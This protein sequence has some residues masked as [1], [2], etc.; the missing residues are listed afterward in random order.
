MNQLQYNAI[1]EIVEP[2]QPLV[3]NTRGFMPALEGKALAYALLNC[4]SDPKFPAVEIGSYMGLSSLYLGAVAR[5]TGRKLISIDHHRGSEEN[6]AGWQ[7]HDPTSVDHVAGKIDTLYRFRRTIDLAELDQTI[8]AVVSDSQIFANLLNGEIGF[9]FIDGGHGENQARSDFQSW[10]P[11][12][13]K[14]GFLAIHDVF[15]DPNLGGRP[16]YQLYLEAL[17]QN[18]SEVLCEGSLRVMEKG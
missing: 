13:V 9:L 16:P 12:I 8:V 5:Q 3:E 14:G 18:Y 4:P 6:Q 17:Q 7:Y 2:L 10:T 15:E 1:N 11:K